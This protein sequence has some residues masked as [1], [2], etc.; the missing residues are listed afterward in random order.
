LKFEGLAN[1]IEFYED[2]SI[3]GNR[4]YR[5]KPYRVA[6][7]RGTFGSDNYKKS[8]KDGQVSSR[9][10]VYPRKSDNCRPLA[11]ETEGL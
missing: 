6:C 9:R 11:R 10:I 5:E 1:I 8:R 2:I 4:F 3:W 7:P